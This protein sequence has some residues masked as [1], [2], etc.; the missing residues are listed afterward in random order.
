MACDEALV[1]SQ[2]H[3]KWAKSSKRALT[4]C[5]SPHEEGQENEDSEL[6]A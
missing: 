3:P 5:V 1:A 2:V 6:H 4:Y